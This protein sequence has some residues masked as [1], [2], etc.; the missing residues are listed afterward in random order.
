MATNREKQSME[1][2]I[3]LVTGANR[4]IGKATAAGLA[5]MGANVVMVCRHREQGELAR[6]EIRAESGNPAVD[7]LVADLASQASIR[8]LAVEFK[9]RYQ[10]LYVLINNAGVAKKGRTLTEDGLETTFAVNHLAPFLLT[11]LLLDMLKT[12]APARI[13]NV[14][15]MVHKWGKIDFDN[16]QGE[17][18]YDMDKAYNQSKLANVLFTYELARRLEGTEVTV[19]S[20]EPGMVVTDFGREY[21]G[22]KAF[23]NRLWRV[24][25]KNPERGAETS[26]YLASSPEVAGISGRHFVDKQAVSSSKSTYDAVLAGRLWDVSETLTRI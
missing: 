17:Q 9:S 18:Q 11:H 25:M 23:M 14:S 6:T 7:L 12:S 3:C 13:I 24:F 2:R 1:G 26:I 10:Q 19:N 4:G 5:K 8:Q 22:L 21:T 15:S 20:L 16:L